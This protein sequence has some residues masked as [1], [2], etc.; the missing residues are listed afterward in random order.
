[1]AGT[2]PIIEIY[3]A[4]PTTVVGFGGRDLFDDIN[5]AVCRDEMLR[6]IEETNCEVLAF[7]LAGVKLIP[8]GLLGLLASVRQHDVEVHLYNPSEDVREVLSVTGLDQI[9]PIHDID[10]ERAE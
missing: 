3:S 10:V 1:M 5:L 7:D 8:S 6:L 2:T 9:M 4:G